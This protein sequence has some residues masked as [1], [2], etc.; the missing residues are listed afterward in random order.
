MKIITT[1]ALMRSTSILEVS[2]IRKISRHGRTFSPR[3]GCPELAPL[4]YDK[5]PVNEEPS[6][7][8]S[9][10]PDSDPLSAVESAE[11]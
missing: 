1:N 7:E 9:P 6:A 11:N 3:N 5:S 4:S 8:R 10:P 2:I